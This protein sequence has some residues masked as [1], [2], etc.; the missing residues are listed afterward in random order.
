MTYP[1]LLLKPAEVFGFL[2]DER[3]WQY[4]K[5]GSSLGSNWK[6]APSKEAFRGAPGVDWFEGEVSAHV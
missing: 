1:E 4:K 6:Y 5:G 2:K 3:G